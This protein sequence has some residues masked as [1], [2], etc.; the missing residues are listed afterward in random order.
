MNETNQ[1][2]DP[3]TK[4]WWLLLVVVPIILAIIAILPQL[5]KKESAS[6]VQKSPSTS[7]EQKAET[8]EQTTGDGHNIT[9]VQGNVTITETPAQDGNKP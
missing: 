4:Y 8:V 3:Q 7:M 6:Q 2:S 5:L 1:K 9:N